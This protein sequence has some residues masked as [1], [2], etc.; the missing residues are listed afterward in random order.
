MGLLNRLKTFLPGKKALSAEINAE[1]DNI[2]NGHNDTHETLTNHLGKQ[3]DRTSADQT[4]DKHVSDK[5]L[6]DIHVALDSK[7]N[8]GDVHTKTVLSSAIDG[9]SG[10][11]KIGATPIA[12]SPNTV[13]GILKWLKTQIDNTALG[14]LPEGSITESKLAFDPATQQELGEFLQSVNEHKADNVKHITAA[15]RTAWNSIKQKHQLTTDTGGC[16]GIVGRNLNEI[17]Q[18]GHYVGDNLINAPGGGAG[19]WYYVEVISSGGDAN[20]VV[21]KAYSYFSNTFY[22]RRCAGGTWQP[23]SAD[24]FTSV[25]NGKWAVRTAILDKGGSVV[26][27]HPNSFVELVNGVNGIN[28]GIKWASGTGT[29][30]NTT[31]RSVTGLGFTPKTVLVRVGSDT[32]NHYVI[33]RSDTM[34]IGYK[35]AYLNT[36]YTSYNSTGDG[37]P[38]NNGLYKATT[39][40]AIVFNVDG[41]TF[42]DFGTSTSFAWIAYA[43]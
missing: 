41:F 30:T 21:Q 7:A 34:T 37:V 14:Q 18:A 39:P 2:I 29:T 1:F 10:A 38:I 25:D 11:D 6:N 8:A 24:L 36:T 4:K 35:D 42:R 26:G 31:T 13:Q 43:T 28:T 15:E 22:I 32:S 20:W 33:F 9:N 40:I 5:D 16:I 23:W 12:N 27:S 17:T 3:V 19:N